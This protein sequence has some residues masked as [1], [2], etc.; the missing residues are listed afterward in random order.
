MVLQHIK[1]H[2][3]LSPDSGLC[4]YWCMFVSEQQNNVGSSSPPNQM[5]EV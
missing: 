3:S 4:Q 1:E 2:M 5:T